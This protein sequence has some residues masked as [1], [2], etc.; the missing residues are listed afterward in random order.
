[1]ITWFSML[2]IIVTIVVVVKLVV[3]MMIRLFTAVMKR[4]FQVQL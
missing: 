1:M 4:K 3:V 2:I